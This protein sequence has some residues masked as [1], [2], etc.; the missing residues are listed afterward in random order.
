[1]MPAL[2]PVIEAGSDQGRDGE[3]AAGT[4]LRLAASARFFSSL[5][6]SLYAEVSV[7]DRHETYAVKS[8]GFCDWLIERYRGERRDLPSPAAVARVVR[9]IEGRARLDGETPMVHV[10]VGRVRD[11][12]GDLSEFYLDLGGSSGQAVKIRARDWSVVDRPPVHFWRPAGLLP[13]PAPSRDGSIELLRR[14]VNLGEADFR[15]LIGW[16][17]AALFPEGPYPILVVHGEQGSA[18]STL[19]KVV[20]LLIDPQASPVL[21]AP[22]STRDLMVTA[23]NGWLMVYD[24]ISTIPGW[25]SDSLC[26]VATGGGFAARALFSD[27]ERKVIHAERPIILNG[28]DEFVRRDDLADRSVFLHLPAIADAERRVESEFWRSFRSEYPAILGGLMSAVADGLH[29]LSSMRLTELPRMADFAC[30][31]EAVGRGLGWP[32][33]T[34]VSAYKENRHAASL[35]SLEDS[36]LAT[37]LLA[38]AKWRGLKDWT[39]CASDMMKALAILVR[40]SVKAS[41]WPKTPR[42]FA[43]ELRRLAPQLRTRGIF[44]TFKRTAE[45]R[46]IT[47]NTDERFDRPEKAR[48]ADPGSEHQ[49]EVPMR[50]RY[51]RA[52]SALM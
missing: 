40:P 45:N 1:M 4:L 43:D 19:A 38:K 26:R 11:S 21:A 15:L 48:P 20:R 34:F 17:A 32:E 12:G 30:L 39:M 9:A 41:G 50:R 42:L 37:A 31:G 16:M 51:V 29:E 22:R 28:I 44:V 5:G 49:G 33:G 52:R 36:A 23:A 14:Y 6:G 46:L 47:I 24:N 8:Q 25:L 2:S 10:R 35:S 27:D 13:L 7:D 3:G 18:K